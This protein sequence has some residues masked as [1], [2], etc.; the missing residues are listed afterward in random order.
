VT[1]SLNKPALVVLAAVAIPAALS[2]CSAGTGSDAVSGQPSIPATQPGKLQICG[3]DMSG[4]V[5]RGEVGVTVPETSNPG[6]A[7]GA[8]DPVTTDKQYTAPA[9]GP[10]KSYDLSGKHQ[11]QVD[12]G[13]SFSY[14]DS[15]RAT[16]VFQKTGA[17]SFSV[18]L[19]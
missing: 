9:D 4:F 16:V 17:K 3:F 5:P 1:R 19:H 14:D 13:K 18:T 11:L 10:C 15:K 8:N 2:A 6:A 7:F 12:G